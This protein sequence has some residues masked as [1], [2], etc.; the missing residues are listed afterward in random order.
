M[1]IVA[2]KPVI[3]EK[4]MNLA[5][6]GVYMFDVSLATNKLMVAKAIKEQFKVDAIQVRAMIIKGK[7]KKFKGVVGKRKDK[8]RVYITVKKGQKIG[9]FNISDK[10]QK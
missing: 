3:T 4:S 8:K 5:A 1:S 6:R 2:L 9:V 7:V 10:E